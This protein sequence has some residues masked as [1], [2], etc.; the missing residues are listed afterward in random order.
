MTANGMA[1]FAP[2]QL[3]N[4]M[5]TLMMSNNFLLPARRTVFAVLVV[6]MVS[7]G[8]LTAC[9]GNATSASSDSGL[10]MASMDG[11]PAEVKSAPTTVQQAYQF[12]VANPDVMKQIPCYCGCGKM[13]HTS[14]Y[15]CYVQN[16]DDKGVVAF[17]THAL[18]CSICVD[19]TQDTM[20]LLKEGK[21]T[22]DIKAYVDQ[23]YSK[24]GPS[25]IP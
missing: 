2:T 9:S 11:M 3:K 6:I 14:N 20:R 19:I 16:V 23:T 5:E 10:A 4:N 18:G 15:S 25:N 12:A 13:G 21:G 8:L 22:A 17:D 7:S 24:Y 1:F